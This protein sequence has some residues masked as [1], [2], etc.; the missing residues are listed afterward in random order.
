MT[1]TL[2]RLVAASDAERTTRSWPTFVV[3]AR[4]SGESKLWRFT[5]SINP[6][7]DIAVMGSEARRMDEMF[8]GLLKEVEQHILSADLG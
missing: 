4:K 1:W 2:W 8:P 5:I 7:T 3:A 6:Q